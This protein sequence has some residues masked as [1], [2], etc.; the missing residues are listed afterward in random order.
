MAT[1]LKTDFL[2]RCLIPRRTE[3]AWVRVCLLPVE[4]GQFYLKY[5]SMDEL[6]NSVVGCKGMKQLKIINDF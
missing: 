6:W 4:G 1:L 2:S 3:G 5:R